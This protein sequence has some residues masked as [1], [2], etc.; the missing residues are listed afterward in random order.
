MAILIDKIGPDEYPL[1]SSISS[2]FMVESIYR[3]DEIDRGLGGLHLVESKI[4][5]PYQKDY[6]AADGDTVAAWAQE[7]DL[8]DWGIFL[9]RDNDKPVGGAAVAVDS[10]VFPMNKF[11]RED[12]AVLWDIRINPD[13][14]GRSVGRKL[15]LHAAEW[16]KSKGYGQLGLETQNINVPACKFYARMGCKL[17]AIHRYGYAGCPPV[18]DEA[19]LLWYYDL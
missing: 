16:A 13:A 7:F 15:F 10:D 5:T 2:S 8:G 3:V 17:G 19:M 6:N 4:E 12:M 14:R 9:A 1:Y 18:A 11:Q